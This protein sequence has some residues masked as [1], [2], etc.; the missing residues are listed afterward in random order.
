MRHQHIPL[1]PA[2]TFLLQPGAFL[3]SR[4]FSRQELSWSASQWR[5]PSWCKFLTGKWIGKPGMKKLEL[6]LVYQNFISSRN[7]SSLRLNI[8]TF[9]AHFWEKQ[10]NVGV[11]FEVP[12]VDIVI[13]FRVSS[14]VLRCVSNHSCEVSEQLCIA[15]TASE[16]LC[17]MC[18]KR[19][20]SRLKPSIGGR[21]ARSW[22]IVIDH[23]SECSV[24]VHC[25]KWVIPG[26]DLVWMFRSR[27]PLVL[28]LGVFGVEA[29]MCESLLPGIFQF[30]S[31]D[32]L[33]FSIPSL[34]SSPMPSA[35]LALRFLPKRRSTER[36]RKTWRSSR[37][38]CLWWLLLI[39][40]FPVRLVLWR[41]CSRRQ[42]RKEHRMQMWFTPSGLYISTISHAQSLFCRRTH[43]IAVPSSRMC[44]LNG[45]RHNKLATRQFC[46]RF[47]DDGS[48]TTMPSDLQEAQIL[49][50]KSGWFPRL[51]VCLFWRR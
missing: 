17:Q 37:K 3:S 1:W 39:S 19:G 14:R 41:R 18:P 12:E 50:C 23:P 47:R 46:K 6:N 5:K 35:H 45:D 43:S 30:F 24:K 9:E 36:E 11:S 40:S 2:R 16:L 4:Q 26:R 34:A 33:P 22:S 20:W 44:D 15:V 27:P 48:F 25:Y 31:P 8:N 42:Q 29:H 7:C 51:S 28:T 38:L 21:V 13:S 10:I 49:I 32:W